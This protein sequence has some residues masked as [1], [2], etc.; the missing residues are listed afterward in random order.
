MSYSLKFL[1]RFLD[2]LLQLF[3][4]PILCVVSQRLRPRDGN[5]VS[6]DGRAFAVLVGDRVGHVN[7][8]VGRR[9]R[10]EVRLHETLATTDEIDIL[11]TGKSSFKICFMFLTGKFVLCL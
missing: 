7:V 9:Q 10:V 8:Q 4:P 1:S 11:G 3:P 2:S 6:L 5:G